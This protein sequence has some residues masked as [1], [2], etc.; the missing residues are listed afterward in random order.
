MDFKELSEKAQNQRLS[1]DNTFTNEDE[2]RYPTED[3]LVDIKV[4]NNNI[5]LLDE[6]KIGGADLQNVAKE[7]S[8]KNIENIVKATQNTTNTINSNV[9]TISSNISTIKSTT[10]TINSNVNTANANI[11]A[12]KTKVDELETKLTNLTNKKAWFSYPNIK[13][14]ELPESKTRYNT[15]TDVLNVSGSGYLFAAFFGAPFIRLGNANIYKERPVK[16]GIKIEIDG[17]VKLYLEAE[18]PSLTTNSVFQYIGLI[19]GSDVATIINAN[20]QAYYTNIKSVFVKTDNLN[21]YDIRAQLLPPYILN[22]AET[23]DYSS[24][25]RKRT[26]TN[27]NILAI[28]DYDFFGKILSNYDYLRFAKSLKIS[29]LYITTTNNMTG[30]PVVNNLYSKI[31]YALD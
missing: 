3:D 14:L 5:R 17:A 22:V 6:Q 4:L 16:I 28:S 12:I 24:T 20:D 10:T 2:I 7:T 13:I 26:L 27:S 25:L 11:N 30:S 23:T 19:D 31:L 1:F 15:Y 9:S 18:Q 29:L 21:Y 8:P